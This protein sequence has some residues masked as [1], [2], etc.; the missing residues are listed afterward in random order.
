MLNSKNGNFKLAS[1]LTAGALA[2]GI[3]ACAGRGGDIAK[4]GLIGAGAGAAIG[5]VVPGVSTVEGAAVGAAGGAI[6]GAVKDNKGRTVYQD[7]NGNKYWIDK[8]G[9][10][11]YY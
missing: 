9:R 11:H 3:S 8:K 7:E 5:A 4:G 10:R 6:Y 2:A 1:F